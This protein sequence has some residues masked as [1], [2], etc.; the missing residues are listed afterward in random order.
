MVVGAEPQAVGA[1]D[2]RALPRLLL[3]LSV[4]GEHLQWRVIG[5]G[6][7]SLEL[8]LLQQNGAIEA[9]GLASVVVCQRSTA[10]ELLQVVAVSGLRPVLGIRSLSLMLSLLILINLLLLLLLLGTF[11]E[12]HHLLLLHQIS[13]RVLVTL[14]L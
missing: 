12:N 11:I 5:D 1:A 6:S 7:L 13:Q 14:L 3:A 4:L 9:I 8:G 2:G 10:I